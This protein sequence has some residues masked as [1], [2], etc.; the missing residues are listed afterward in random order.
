MNSSSNNWIILSDLTRNLIHTITNAIG[1]MLISRLV[2]DYFRKKSSQSNR[3]TRFDSI[4]N[5][6]NSNQQSIYNQ[7]ETDP[8]NDR[9]FEAAH[10]GASDSSSQ[11][12]FISSEASSSRSSY[13]DLMD[14]TDDNQNCSQI[15]RSEILESNCPPID[16]SHSSREKKSIHTT[17]KS[18]RIAIERNSHQN[19]ANHSKSISLKRNRFNRTISEERFNAE[20]SRLNTFADFEL[21]VP[22]SNESLQDRI[23]NEQRYREIRMTREN[24]FRITEKQ[25]SFLKHKITKLLNRLESEYE[26]EIAAT[27]DEEV[28]Q[29]DSESPNDNNV[30]SSI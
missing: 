12:S 10:L 29:L 6:K 26:A 1:S 7:K 9:C 19:S 4:W 17:K 15:D 18:R 5:E 23:D 24:R 3:A 2:A 20:G 16:Q 11:S 8:N 14:V 30:F 28:N 21:S 27:P 13:S 22:T 25:F